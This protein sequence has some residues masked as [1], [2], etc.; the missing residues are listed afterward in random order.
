MNRKE[1]RAEAKATHNNKQ[2]ETMENAASTTALQI[3]E[4]TN[5]HANIITEEDTMEIIT[6]E[7]QPKTEQL[8]FFT[9]IKN[10]FRNGYREGKACIKEQVQEIKDT[11]VSVLEE[12]NN[13]VIAHTKAVIKTTFHILKKSIKALFSLIA[14]PFIKIDS[15]IDRKEEVLS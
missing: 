7:L 3:T 11:Y 5:T 6:S 14:L 10:A 13:P 12:S 2:E 8:G 9:R 4:E 15:F 1:R